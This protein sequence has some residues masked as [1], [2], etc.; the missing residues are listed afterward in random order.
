M[1]VKADATSAGISTFANAPKS[2]TKTTVTAPPNPPACTLRCIFRALS[3]AFSELIW[4]PVR[5][6]TQKGSSLEELTDFN[7][8]KGRPRNE[9][10]TDVPSTKFVPEPIAVGDFKALVRDVQDDQWN[11]CKDF[12]GATA[13]RGELFSRLRCPKSIKGGK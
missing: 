3:V 7:F 13:R 10:A 2:Q 5:H 8:K 4:Y 1:T 9:D 6:S 11:G 12:E